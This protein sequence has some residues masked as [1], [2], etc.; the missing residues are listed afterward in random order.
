M[1]HEQEADITFSTVAAAAKLYLS[2]VDIKMYSIN[3]WDNFHLFTRGYETKSFADLKG[4]K[5]HVPLFKQASPMVMTKHLIEAN[6]Y[7]INDFEFN[8]GNPFGRPEEIKNDFIAGENDTVLLREPEASYAMYNVKN[9]YESISYSQLWKEDGNKI[10]NIPNAG[11]I[12]KGEFL[13]EHP[14]VAKV[15]VEELEKATT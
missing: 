12:F 2:G 11:L 15:F 10:G 1:G 7:N 6:G 5:I 9:A 14:D 4:H 13:R 3:I 8:F